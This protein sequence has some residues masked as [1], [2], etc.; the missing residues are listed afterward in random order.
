MSLQQLLEKQAQTD[1]ALV[2]SVHAGQAVA[3]T[4]IKGAECEVQRDWFIE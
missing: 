4:N 3:V 1:D 2:V